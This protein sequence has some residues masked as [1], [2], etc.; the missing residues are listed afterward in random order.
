MD[1]QLA[2]TVKSS[3]LSVILKTHRIV[4]I[5]GWQGTGKTMTTLHAAAETGPVYYFSAAGA[6][7]PS[8]SS[9]KPLKSLK[10]L[11]VPGSGN[12]VLVI[13][14][15]DRMDDAGRSGLLQYLDSNRWSGK[16]VVIS[17]TQ[18]TSEGFTKLIDAAVRIKDETA[19]PIYSRHLSLG[20]K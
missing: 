5:V 6:G 1:R 2:R 8:D 12:A 18:P 4:L 17:R 11:P 15:Y 14:D 7:A 9:T 3:I 16:V 13:D 20:E 19:E 10:D